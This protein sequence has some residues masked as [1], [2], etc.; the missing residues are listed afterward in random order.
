MPS[1]ELAGAGK[2]WEA[3]QRS[4]LYPPLLQEPLLTL[5]YSIEL[6]MKVLELLRPRRRCPMGDRINAS[7]PLQL[8]SALSVSLAP[9]LCDA[10]EA[11]Q[12]VEK[13]RRKEDLAVEESVK[14]VLAWAQV[15]RPKNTTRAYLPKQREWKVSF[16]PSSVLCLFYC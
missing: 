5:L 15:H 12:E 8:A 2:V 3:G 9:A 4:V 1:E 11:C 6:N 7:A 16:P 14:E 10:Q 13:K